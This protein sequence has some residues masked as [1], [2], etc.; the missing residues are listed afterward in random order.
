MAVV[1]LDDPLQP[2]LV[3]II[4][5]DGARA[6]ALQFRYL[7]VTDRTGF[8]VVD[9]TDPA[10]PRKV[11]GASVSL[12]QA[13]RIYMAR[14]MA[15]VA[16]GRD[17]LVI[18]D[19]ENPESPVVHERFTANGQINDARDVI[20]GT[21]NA[22]LFAY[23]ADGRNGLKVVQL[24]SPE[25]QSRFYGFSSDPKPEL[26]AWYSTEYPATALSKGLDRD[27]GV[28]ETGNQIAIFGRL[29]SRPFTQ[30][31]QQKLYLNERGKPWFV[32]NDIDIDAFVPGG[33]SQRLPELPQQQAL[34]P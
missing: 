28:D 33:P 1:N 2:E 25:S 5:F 8:H 22:S 30:Q 11:D 17:G 10:N 23:V 18:I 34:S 13:N 6:T 4:P 21:T 27:R 26:I 20:V 32:N 3:T 16:A 9:V 24:T 29:G 31:E 15:H 12:A 14:T 7:F 19:T